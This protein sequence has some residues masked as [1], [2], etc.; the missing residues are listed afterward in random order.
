MVHREMRKKLQLLTLM[1]AGALTFSANAQDGKIVKKIPLHLELG[2]NGGTRS[3][4]VQPFSA[5][6]DLNYHII[7]RLSIRAVSSGDYFLPKESVTKDYNYTINLGGGVGYTIVPAGSTMP[8]ALEAR[9]FVTTSLNSSYFKHTSYNIGFYLYGN[10][11]TNWIVPL[12][13]IGYNMK[14]YKAKHLSSYNGAYIT[15]GIRF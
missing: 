1:F 7:P 3:H 12:V 13:G 10:S 6:F 14:D 4:E 8:M 11:T 2:L 15:L 5:I 9:A